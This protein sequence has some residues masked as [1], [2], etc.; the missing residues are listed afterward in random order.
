MIFFVRVCFLFS[1]G[2]GFGFIVFV[3]VSSLVYIGDERKRRKRLVLE[4]FG[5]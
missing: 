5:S 2:R 1:V 4:V 3:V